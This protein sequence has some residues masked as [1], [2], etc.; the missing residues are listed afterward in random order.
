MKKLLMLV[1]VISIAATSYSASKTFTFQDFMPNKMIEST[2][3]TEKKIEDNIVYPVFEGSTPLISTMNKEVEKVV[4]KYKREPQNVLISYDMKA[5]NS[6][7]KSILFTIQKLDENTKEVKDIEYVTLNFDT[8][9]GKT[10]ELGDLFVSGYND[11][12]NGVIQ[13]RML[14]FGLKTIPNFKGV[15]RYQTFYLTEHTLVIIFNKGKATETAD[16]IAFLPFI[17]QE[18]IGILK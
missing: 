7:F 4:F 12:L 8:K 13:E 1:T 9:S 10:L 6:Y 17:T 14:Q 18:L 11:A 5:D 15:T 3:I 16:K 2:K